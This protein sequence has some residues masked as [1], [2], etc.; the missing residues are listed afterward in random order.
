MLWTLSVRL[1]WMLKSFLLEDYDHGTQEPIGLPLCGHSVSPN[2][3]HLNLSYFL[4]ITGTVMGT[5]IASMGDWEDYD[6][7]MRVY[8]QCHGNVSEYIMY[9]SNPTLLKWSCC[10][11]CISRCCFFC[12]GKL[13]NCHQGFSFW[14]YDEW[15]RCS[16]HLSNAH[17]NH[18]VEMTFDRSNTQPP[19]QKKISRPC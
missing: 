2:V 14:G 8:T 7:L 9:L 1:T 4:L 13:P 17:S 18:H 19:H 10:W 6:W 3:I 12:L 5:L 15:V 11:W 16:Q